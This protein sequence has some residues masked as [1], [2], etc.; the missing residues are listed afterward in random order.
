MNPLEQGASAA[1]LICPKS[2]VT[3]R[4]VTG[5]N[6]PIVFPTAIGVQWLIPF[7]TLIAVGP[8]RWSLTALTVLPSRRIVAVK[9]GARSKLVK[10]VEL[11]PT[12][13]LFM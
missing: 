11:L 12:V 1:S 9:P 8:F 2:A 7:P 3:L 10:P 5:L 13:M 4:S 6:G